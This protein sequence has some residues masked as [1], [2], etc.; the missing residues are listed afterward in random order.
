MACDTCGTFETFS[1][2]YPNLL[3]A[4]WLKEKDLL[5][6]FFSSVDVN[7][8]LRCPLF[9]DARVVLQLPPR[10]KILYWAAE[11]SAQREYQQRMYR[12]K[13]SYDFFA[14]CGVAESDGRGR[15]L[16]AL[17]TPAIYKS[18]LK[19][20]TRYWPRHLHFVL[21]E[22]DSW[23]TQCYTKVLLPELSL[24]RVKQAIEQEVTTC[25]PLK[26]LPLIPGSQFAFGPKD[27]HARGVRQK[28]PIIVYCANRDCPAAMKLAE[29]LLRGGFVNV[30]HFPGGVEEFQAQQNQRRLRE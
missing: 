11:A 25:C 6:N 21:L 2:V 23:G 20:K 4:A 24:D 15:C 9:A 7:T 12:A 18:K 5:K 28:D 16:C 14:N 17:R 13:R 19:G 8:P 26:Q 3:E 29:R 22:G 1:E 27:L 10:Q 30:F